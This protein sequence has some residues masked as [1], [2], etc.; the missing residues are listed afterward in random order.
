[1]VKKAAISELALGSIT[2]TSLKT[3]SC[4]CAMRTQTFHSIVHIVHLLL[5]T[6][7]IVVKDQHL[8]FDN[9][10]VYIGQRTSI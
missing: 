3:L 10:I 8:N 2:S 7:L 6:F 1:M 9:R 5:Y 4:A